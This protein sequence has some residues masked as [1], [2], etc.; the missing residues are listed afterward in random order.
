MCL[1]GR[2]CREESDRV[3]EPKCLKKKLL[4]LTSFSFLFFFFQWLKHASVEILVVAPAVA[5]RLVK[6]CL[7]HSFF[8]KVKIFFP[9]VGALSGKN[10]L[11]SQHCQE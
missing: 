10:T 2:A 9:E 3:T 4:P 7:Q 1:K 5:L 11:S 6:S 8:L